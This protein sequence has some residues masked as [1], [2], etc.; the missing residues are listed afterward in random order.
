MAT[1]PTALW[2]ASGQSYSGERGAT[3]HP[4]VLGEVRFG[5]GWDLAFNLGAR[6]RVT[7]EARLVSVPVS[8][9]FTY[10]VGLVMP[11]WTDAEGRSVTGHVEAYGAFTLDAFGQRA[12]SPFEAIVG[13]RGQPICGLQLGLAGGTGLSRGYGTPDVRGVFSVGW[14]DAQCPASAEAEG[15]PVAAVVGEGDADGDGIGDSRDACPT[16]PEDRDGF[17]DENGCPDADNDRDTLIDPNDRCPLAPGRVEDGGCPR[18]VQFDVARGSI[19]ALQNVEFAT[20]QDVILERSFPVLQDVYN[21][22]NANPQL[23]RVRIE[24]HTDDRSDDAHNLD[25]SRRRAASVMRWLIEHGV[26]AGRVEAWG[27]GELYPVRENSTDAG[28]QANRRVEFQIL[29]PAPTAANPAAQR[30]MCIPAQ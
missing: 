19:L 26:S 16:Q 12:V 27:C 20:D 29:R 25:L 30:P 7:D 22:L 18:T 5:D 28:R 10:G 14:S 11:F 2:A 1:L 15:G 8:H 17:E 21:I 24:G 3:L 13:V 6:V 4:E 9:E 23:E